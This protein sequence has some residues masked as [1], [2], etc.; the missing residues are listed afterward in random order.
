[1]AVPPRLPTCSREKFYLFSILISTFHFSRCMCMAGE[2]SVFNPHNNSM[3]LMVLFI[4]LLLMR[5][6]SLSVTGSPAPGL[7][8]IQRQCWD[9]NP[10]PGARALPEILP[11]PPVHLSP[12][13]HKG[14]GTG[15][16][17]D[18]D[19]SPRSTTSY[20][21]HLRQ[22]AQLLWPSVSSSVK[23]G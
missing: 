18:P 9:S 6:L 15:S 11:Q 10:E 14:A 21:C 1:M 22:V 4:S 7:A 19:S 20:L 16:D 23:W 8:A 17:R 5:K 12:W 2:R 3:E 13:V